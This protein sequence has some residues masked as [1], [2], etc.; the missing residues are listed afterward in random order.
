MDVQKPTTATTP[1]GLEITRDTKSQGKI[2]TDGRQDIMTYGQLK[3][4]RVGLQFND[5]S[6]ERLF[7]GR[8]TTGDLVFKF[9]QSGYDASTADDDDLILSSQFNSFKIAK[10]MNVST[11]INY[12]SGNQNTWFNSS[13]TAHDLGYAPAYVAFITIPQAIAGGGALPATNLPNPALVYG[14][15]TGIVIVVF[16]GQVSVDATNVTIAGQIGQTIANSNYVISAKVYLLKE[17]Q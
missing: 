7:M 5:S 3:D 16:V 8:D 11:T 15:A 2:V 1:N 13:A 9:S 4:G 14:T 12:N 6:N 10:I 17:T